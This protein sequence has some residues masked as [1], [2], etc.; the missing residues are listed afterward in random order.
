VGAAVGME[1]IPDHFKWAV[2][3]CDTKSGGHPRPEFLHPK[4]I[5]DLVQKILK[6]APLHLTFSLDL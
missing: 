2:L 6:I 3:E 4:Q 1:G 5:P